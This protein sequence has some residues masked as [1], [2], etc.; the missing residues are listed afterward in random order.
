[1]QVVTVP[2]APRFFVPNAEPG[3]QEE[4]YAALAS[5]ARRMMY[6]IEVPAAATDRIY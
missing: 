2:Q 3:E 5:L 6:D 4:T 1:M